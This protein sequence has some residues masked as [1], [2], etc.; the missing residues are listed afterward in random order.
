MFRF[1]SSDLGIAD[2]AIEQGNNW[3]PPKSPPGVGEDC[4]DGQVS[5]ALVARTGD[6][7]CLKEVSKGGVERRCAALEWSCRSQRSQN[8]IAKIF[9]EIE[10]IPWE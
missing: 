2:L 7:R 6:C 10:W 9:S 8:K 4:F 3:S 1:G 5:A